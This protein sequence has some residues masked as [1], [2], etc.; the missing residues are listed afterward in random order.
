MLTVK[1]KLKESGVEGMG[2]F[3]DEDI[4]KGTVTWRFDK[5]IDIVFDPEDVE[6]MP[7]EKQNL[8]KKYAFLSIY[9]GKYIYSIDDSRFINHSAKNFN[10]INRTKEM[11]G[12]ELIEVASRDIKKGEEILV[13]YRDF[14]A[15]DK[16]SNEE[17]LNN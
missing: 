3:A 17:Y 7:K 1:T 14:D 5:D 12:D 8:I 4:S 6:K 11:K 2:L 16:T 15:H 10:V 13:N 9:S